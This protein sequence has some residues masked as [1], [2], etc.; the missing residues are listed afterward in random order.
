M[1]LPFSRGHHLSLRE[2]FLNFHIYFYIISLSPFDN[3]GNIFILSSLLFHCRLTTIWSNGK[4]FSINLTILAAHPLCA[5]KKVF[6]FFIRILLLPLYHHLIQREIFFK[7]FQLIIK[8]SRVHHLNTRQNFIK[9]LLY[10]N[11]FLYYSNYF[12]ITKKM[13]N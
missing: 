11:I 9:N 7:L 1:N 10:V 4:I 12:I 3:A 5:A 8:I 6:L 2:K 13:S